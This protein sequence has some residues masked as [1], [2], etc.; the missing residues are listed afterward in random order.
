M[1]NVSADG[2]LGPLR[3]ALNAEAY[4]SDGYDI[5]PKR[6]AAHTGEAD[7][8]EMT[9]LTGLVDYA[10]NRALGLDLLLR[11]R[12]ARADYDP[13]F[14]GDIGEN[15]QAEIKQ[16]DTAL[17]R[18]GA[19]WTLN[20]SLS[21]R[22]S[23]GVLDTD[24]VA[25]EAGVA[26]DEYH[27]QRR[28]ADLTAE[29]NAGAWRYVFGGV[30]EDENIDA[31]SFG[32]P[33]MGAQTHSGA[34]I[35][36]QRAWGGLDFTGALRRDEFEGFGG[37]T[38]WRAGV[39]YRSNGAARVHASYGASYR[40]PSLYELHAPFFGAS[41]LTPERATSWEVGADA[42]FA[43]SGRD[44]GL[45]VGALY[46][47]SQI[48]DLIGFF[49]FTYANVD[50]AA[51]NF[52]EARVSVRPLEWLTASAVYANTDARDAGSGEA[53]LRRPR[54]AW[55]AEL[56]A[57]HG[58]F[59]AQVSWREVGARVDTAYSDLGLFSGAQRVEAYDT[60]SASASWEMSDAVKL[61]VAAD[62]ILAETYEPVNGF[63]GAPASV[64][65][66]VRVTP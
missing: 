46:R 27:G 49:G 56:S 43:L 22:L 19:T 62:N 28:F 25:A 16:N 55:S 30:G 50:R 53:L 58:P 47:S 6:I 61:Y 23:G 51:I 66:G 29:W 41:S 12:T 11:R 10:L 4:S 2:T 34:F 5:V 38:T 54:H 24:R 21:L 13:G 45:H 36:A 65:F 32:S 8:A 26:G 39:S 59:S 63:A 57:A 37:A 20:E 15:P 48:N 7:G 44:D 64:M 40:A 1:G 14:F 33:I 3:Y 60:V 31:V 17:W 35:A 42:R 18:L 9:T 52:A